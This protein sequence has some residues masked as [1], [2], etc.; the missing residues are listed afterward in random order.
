MNKEYTILHISDLHKSDEDS[1]DDL[2]ESMRKDS[3]TYVQQGISLPEIVVVSGD[4]VEGAKDDDKTP[5]DTIR[6]QYA[7]AKVFLT[8][9]CDYFL[10]G[11]KRR[12]ILVPGNHDLNRPFSK[13]VLVPSSKDRKTDYQKYK[14]GE[15]NLR[16]SW[17]DFAFQI[18]PDRNL[19]E[20]RFNHYVDFYNDFY[21]GSRLT[22][23]DNAL[24]GDVIDLPDYNMSFLTLNSCHNL[25]RYNDAGSIFTG[26]VSEN[27]IRLGELDRKGRLLC[28]V[29]HHHISGLPTEHNYMDYRILSTMMRY[30]IQVGLFG[31]QH[32]AKVVQQYHDVT[33]EKEMLL[34]SS[35]CLYG[36]AKQ[37]TPSSSRQ[38]NL[39]SITM[40]DDKAEI[41]IRT[42]MDESEGQYQ[43]PSWG[44]GHPGN[45]KKTVIRKI[46][47]LPKPDESLTNL[48]NEVDVWTRTSEDYK[49]GLAKMVALR[50][51]NDIVERYIDEYLEK[52]KPEDIGFVLDVI[53]EPL[54]EKQAMYLL[55]SAQTLRNKTLLSSLRQMDFIKQCN[56]PMVKVL[57]DE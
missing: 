54:T 24:H 40:K 56:S 37:L 55:G 10:G 50:G 33:E 16:W 11:E 27:G 51:T 8:A 12:L 31:H 45:T 29:W 25:D 1:Y 39:I 35:G 26:A 7:D 28:G 6:K 4:I 53:K 13:N 22:H 20:K 52:M 32:K 36:N 23:E 17:E 49:A 15:Q 9:L 57:R 42:R 2:F 14:A 34:I 5:D 30:N 46:I 38:Y 41:E 43:Y 47:P 18:I 44:E 48:I 3:E 19:Y 21:E